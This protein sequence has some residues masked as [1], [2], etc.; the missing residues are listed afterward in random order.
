MDAPPA[1]PS[2]P[3]SSRSIRPLRKLR[4]PA[5]AAPVREG[6]STATKTLP[7]KVLQGARTRRTDTARAG[8]GRDTLFVTRKTGLGALIARARSLVVDEG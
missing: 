3:S 8:F 5:P 6:K 2:R 4:P 1:G 7:T